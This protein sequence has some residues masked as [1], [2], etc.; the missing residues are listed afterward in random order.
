M[1]AKIKIIVLSRNKSYTGL[2]ALILIS[3]YLPEQ[4][5]APHETLHALI[6]KTQIDSIMKIDKLNIVFE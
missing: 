4:Q 6:L 1:P 2:F 3:N 5:F